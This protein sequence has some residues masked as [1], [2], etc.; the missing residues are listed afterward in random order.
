M[1]I[2]E[3]LKWRYATK[4][5]DKDKKVSETDFKK[6]QDVIQLTATSFGLQFYKVLNVKD[7][8]IREELQKVSFGQPQITDASHLLVFGHYANIS[9]NHVDDFIEF[10]AQER[11][12]KVEMLQDYSQMMKGYINS[13]PDKDAWAARQTYLVLGTLMMAAAEMKIDTCPIEGFDENQYDE[14]LGMKEKGLKTVVTVALG[15]RST[16]DEYQHAKKVR[17]S[18]DELFIDV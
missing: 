15:Y 16:E 17:R 3:N 13:R 8:E 14:I 7:P 5:F 12:L 6:L 4:K 1:N 11:N 10:I 18:M 2:I 9:D